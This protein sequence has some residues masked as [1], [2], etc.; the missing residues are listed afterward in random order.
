MGQGQSQQNVTEK[1]EFSESELLKGFSTIP[2]V[3]EKIVVVK[4]NNHNVHIFLKIFDKKRI[5]LDFFYK[6]EGVTKKGIARCALFALLNRVLALKLVDH[7]AIVAV[8][9]E[10]VSAVWKEDNEKEVRLIKI[11]K[12]I[13]FTQYDPEPGDPVILRAS[14]HQLI[15]TL[16]GQCEMTGG[17]K[18]IK[19]KSNKHKSKK[20]RKRKSKKRKITKRKTNKR[21]KRIKFNHKSKKK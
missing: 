20:H 12:E 9:P 17:G 10:G 19:T 13:G 16:S 2:R 15:K 6:A 8:R 5:D 14:V 3:D 7:K 18:Y 4:L 21:K 1:I 11:Y